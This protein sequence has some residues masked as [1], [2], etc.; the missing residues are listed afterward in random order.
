MGRPYP[1]SVIA[2]RTT[3]NCYNP[4]STHCRKDVIYACFMMVFWPRFLLFA[5]ALASD[6]GP[7]FPLEPEMDTTGGV[8]TSKVI[9]NPTSQ[10]E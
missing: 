4:V 1:Y 3:V 5:P 2:L 7:E 10:E 6:P 8:I 9:S